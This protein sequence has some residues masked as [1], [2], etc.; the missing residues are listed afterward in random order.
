MVTAPLMYIHNI[1]HHND[2]ININIISSQCHYQHQHHLISIS[3]STSTSSHINIIININIISSQYHHQHQRHL[4]SILSSALTS[5][6]IT[7][8]MYTYNFMSGIHIP[9]LFRQHKSHK[10]IIS[11]TISLINNKYIASH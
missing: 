8:H 11:F 9:Q 1:H 5:S 10:T 4:I 6:V 2:I 3:S 7:F